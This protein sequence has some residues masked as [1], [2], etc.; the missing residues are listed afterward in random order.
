[1]QDNATI[2]AAAWLHGTSDYQQRV[3]KASQV[4]VRQVQEFLFAPMNRLYLNQFTDFLIQRLAG[5]YIRQKEFENPLAWLK[6]EQLTHGQTVQETAFKWLRA[7]S[8]NSDDMATSTILKTHYP[9]GASAYHSVNRRDRY[10]I[11]YTYEQLR[12]AFESEYGL[13]DFI[14]AITM[15]PR[16]SDNYDE[17]QIMKQLFAE[18]HNAHGMFTVHVDEPTDESTAKALLRKLREYA[19]R[20]RFPSTLYNAL[21]VCDIPVFV[22][23]PADLV[24]FVDPKTR[25]TLDVEAL[26]ALFHVELA[27]VPYR[28]QVLDTMPIAN[29]VAILAPRD[30]FMVNDTVNLTAN[31]RNP[32]S[33]VETQ[34][35]HR[36]GIY[37]VSP[38]VPVIRFSTDE[39][40]GVPTIT[41]EVTGVE[42]VAPE[43]VYLND[44]RSQPAL[45]A[46]LLG[47]IDGEEG[48]CLADVGV[49]PDAALFTVT[50]VKDSEGNDLAWTEEQVLIY[51]NGELYVQARGNSKLARAVRN[52][53][54]TLTIEGTATYINPSGDTQEFTDTATVKVECK[55]ED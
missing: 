39:D 17:Y 24:L 8:Y 5:H 30:F 49:R 34:W 12:E 11:S 35:L 31:F 33:L 9:E 23:D 1:M 45:V 32:E 48:C 26:A 16:N 25:S 38:F 14:S 7:H 20:L 40:T 44:K 18:F 3:P 51:P 28:V 47:T 10:Q 55:E 6:N 27:D 53:G 46:N 4:G 43:T 52:G 29:T 13:N 22:N 50:S 42:I 37:S 41:E 21:D 19:D 2:L 15:L 54:V 36:W